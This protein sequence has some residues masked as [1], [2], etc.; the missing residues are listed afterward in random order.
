MRVYRIAKAQYARDLSGEGSRLYGGRWTPKGQPTVYTSEHPALAAWELA[1]RYDFPFDAA[2]LDH[3]LVEIELPEDVTGAMI[4][5]SDLPNDPLAIGA[6]W[7]AKGSSL[8]LRVPS[9]VIPQSYNILINPRHPDMK[10]VQ[11]SGCTTFTFD[12][13]VSTQD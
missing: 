7:L 9:V 2:P 5:V 12:A 13:R 6:D 3:R 1:I 11:V 8:L 4:D 10:Q